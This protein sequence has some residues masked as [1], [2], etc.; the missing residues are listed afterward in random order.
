MSRFRAL[1]ALTV[2]FSACAMAETFT[3]IIT[4]A[5]DGAKHAPFGP[6]D[7][8]AMKECFAAGAVPVLL[9][10]DGKMMSIFYVSVDRVL[11]HAGE[12]V[13]ITGKVEQARGGVILIVETI[14]K[15][16]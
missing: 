15:A 7:I 1:A 10:A 8:A 13:T 12:K 2:L 3:G 4:D 9:T 11:P 14:E 5:R 6:A 16:K